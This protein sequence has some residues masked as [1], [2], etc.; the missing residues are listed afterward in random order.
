MGAEIDRRALW[1]LVGRQHGVV[2]ST[3]LRQLGLTPKAIRHRIVAGRLHRI[4]GGV[5]A[6]GRPSLTLY[7]RWMAAVLS[8]GAGAVLSHDSAA[9]LW[10]IR[11]T[12]IRGTEVSVGRTRRR[13]GVIVHRRLLVDREI[14][15]HRGIPVVTPALT[16]VDIAARAR[17][18]ELEAAINAADRLNLADPE[19]LRAE[20]GEMGRRPGLRALRQTLDR[21]TF[22]LTDSELERR[23]LPVARSA[24]LTAPETQCVVNGYR[25]DFW[26]PALRLVVETDGLRYHRTPAQQ[27][28]DRLRDQAHAAAGLTSLR[29][30]HGQVYYQPGRVA[31]TL[32]AVAGRA[33][34]AA[35]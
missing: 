19:K 29:F 24:G 35:P 28:A 18:N 3:Q 15:C 6:V 23:F 8:C 9:A 16:L 4:H 21:L 17:R 34:G 25:V 33:L 31:A 7:G 11:T 26:W 12:Q 10:E 1:E 30:T 2:A 27:A 13:P 22:T 20:L 5:Y 32:A 14:T